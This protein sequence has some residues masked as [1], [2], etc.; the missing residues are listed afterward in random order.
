M[1]FQADIYRVLIASPGDLHEERAVVSGAI[2]AW[3]AQHSAAE[4]VVL[5]PVR[6]ETHTRPESGTR[7]Q[8]AINRQIVDDCDILVGLFWTRLGTNTGVAASGTIEEIE[9][10]IGSG[11]P[12]LLYFSDR[13]VAPSAV[14]ARQLGSLKNFHQATLV[15]S[16]TGT[17]DSL[18]GLAANLQ[19]DLL[20]QVRAMTP[21]PRVP[22]RGTKIDQAFQVTQLMMLHKQ[23]AIAPAEFAAFQQSLLGP[24][25]RSPAQTSEPEAQGEVGPNGHRI[26]YTEAGDKVEWLP[27]DEEA[28]AE[29]PMLL[30]RNDALILKS[31]NEFWD[32]V[33]WNR[34]Q[35][36]MQRI[37]RGEEVITSSQTTILETAKRA[38]RRI[39][40]KYGKRNLGWDDFEWGLLSGRMS[41]LSWVMGSEWHESLDT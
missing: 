34:H 31:Y 14:D 6:W 26:G 39:E 20:A 30:R 2:E 35:C 1:S 24:R 4:G 25:T 7:P 18:E 41:A 38:A 11:K 13:P 17:F 8:E 5:L 28:G 19:R 15:G 9:R 3:N 36:W 40:R 37:E 32:K 10:T 29:W 33:W 22:R 23:N 27:D 12:A 21:P 16:L